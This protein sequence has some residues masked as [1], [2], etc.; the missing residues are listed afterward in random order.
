[1]LEEA[2]QLLEVTPPE[3]GRLPALSHMLRRG[4][5]RKVFGSATCDALV[6]ISEA[7]PV[8]PQ[9]GDAWLERLSP[10]AA[11]DPGEAQILA[12]A[13]EASLVVLSSDKRA[14]RAV[15]GIPEFAQA[16]SGRVVVL[17]AVLVGLCDRLAP[18]EVRRRVQPLMPIDTMIQACF[19]TGN[20][21]PVEA[22][23]SYYDHLAAELAPLILW[24]PRSRDGA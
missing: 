9:A 22:L 14:L 19:S 5:L 21:R 4:R 13:A 7:I 12:R 18:D 23:L 2:F 6:P 20:A 10:I 8:L 17:E 16:L 3:C 11:I 24:N 15:N 1:M